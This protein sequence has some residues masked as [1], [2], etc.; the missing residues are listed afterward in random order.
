MFYED[1]FEDAFSYPDIPDVHP[2]DYDPIPHVE[3]DCPLCG[4]GNSSIN[5]E[6]QWC[7]GPEDGSP[8]DSIREEQKHYEM[9]RREE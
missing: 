9:L 2:H 4:C 8:E 7:N 5:G 1:V 3:W 6:C